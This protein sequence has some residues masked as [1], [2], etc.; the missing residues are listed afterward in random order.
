MAYNGYRRLR[1]RIIERYGTQGKFAKAL[2][3]TDQT[4][5]G[6]L[7]G[8]IQF[9]QEDIIKWSNLLGVEVNDV[10][11]FFFAERLSKYESI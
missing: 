7:S 3:I 11:A 9:S 2:G 4:L 1:G 10:G 8:R 5:T 6:K